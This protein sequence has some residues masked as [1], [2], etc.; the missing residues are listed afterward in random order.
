MLAQRSRRGTV[1]Q[2]LYIVIDYNTYN[3]LNLMLYGTFWPWSI[4]LTIRVDEVNNNNRTQVSSRISLHLQMQIAE[5]PVS[6]E[7]NRLI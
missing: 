4:M 7:L 1:D 6:S 5:V 3:L 2:N